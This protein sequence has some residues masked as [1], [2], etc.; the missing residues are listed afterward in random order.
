MINERIEVKGPYI[1]PPG[2]GLLDQEPFMPG[3]TAIS[4]R[5]LPDEG[6]TKILKNQIMVG[7]RDPKY[8]LPRFPVFNPDDPDNLA[9][10]FY[11]GRM[12]DLKDKHS[13]PVVKAV[14]LAFQ[15]LAR[16][17]SIYPNSRRYL[18]EMFRHYPYAYEPSDG[19]WRNERVIKTKKDGDTFEKIVHLG[20]MDLAVSYPFW[21]TQQQIKRRIQSRSQLENMH[22]DAEVVEMLAGKNPIVFQE[23]SWSLVLPPETPVL[24]PET[25]VLTSGQYKSNF[26]DQILG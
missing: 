11:R 19:N 3:L 14:L 2:V 6:L 20:D 1:L 10:D 21:A 7:A 22:T 12:T 26:L 8:D 5:V 25:T 9:V 16:H 17:L 23:R 18:D 13:V 4:G 24:A 15:E